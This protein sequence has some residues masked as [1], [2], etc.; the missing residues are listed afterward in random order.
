[1]RFA[2]NVFEDPTENFDMSGTEPGVLKAML[3]RFAELETSCHRPMANPAND[4]AGQ[5]GA[6]DKAKGFVAPWR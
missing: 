4:E 3:A 6:V 2:V 1:M 5:C